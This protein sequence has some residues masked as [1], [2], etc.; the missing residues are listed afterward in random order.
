MNRHTE[1]QLS[2]APRAIVKGKERTPQARGETHRIESRYPMVWMVLRR[3]PLGPDWRQ[4]QLALDGNPGEP[5]MA[6]SEDRRTSRLFKTHK[7]ASE[8]GLFLLPSGR[9]RVCMCLITGTEPH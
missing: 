8:P 7:S 9:T 3:T 5:T 6:P 2:A 1:N 4:W